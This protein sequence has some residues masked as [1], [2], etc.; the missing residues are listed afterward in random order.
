MTYITGEII[1]DLREKKNMTQ[2]QLA[3][4]L[5]VSDKTISKWE[6]NRGL[7]DVGILTDLA[8][9]LSVSVPEL[10]TGNVAMNKNVSANMK[11]SKFYVCPICG[12]VIHAMGSGAF[13]CCGIRLPELE[14]ET[15]DSAHEIHVENVENEL[16]VYLDHP[17]NKEHY[18]S[19]IAMITDS[20]IQVEKLYPEQT[21]QLRFRKM[22]HGKLAAYCNRHGLYVRSI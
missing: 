16:F 6:N 12:N 18:I 19:F 4:K 8:K 15:P 17:M 7:P 10:L 1:K 20:H 5:L 22:G 2:K 11:R 21:P 14:E 3:E 9:A 13:S